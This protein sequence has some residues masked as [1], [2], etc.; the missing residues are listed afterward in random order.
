MV[1]MSLLSRIRDVLPGGKPLIPRE[2]VSYR[3]IGVV[4]SPVR[5]SRPDGWENVRS[6]LILRDELAPALDAIEGFSHVIVVFHIDRVPEEAQ[7]LQI[8]VGSEEAPPERGV[9]ATRSQLRPNP[10]GTS[11]VKVLHRRKAVLR[12]QGLDALDGTP[13]LDIKPYLPEY[14]AVPGAELPPWARHRGP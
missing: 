7:R 4:R 10:I 6:D 12:V 1:R 14:D 13:V 3:P 2:P 9:L 11:V 5:R 8:P